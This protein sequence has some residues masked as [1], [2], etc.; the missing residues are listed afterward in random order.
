MIIKIE[1]EEIKRDEPIP[2]CAFLS[3]RYG[4]KPLPIINKKTVGMKP[5]EF[6]ANMTFY[7]VKYSYF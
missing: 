1:L 2:P 5:N 7:K 3:F 6:D 4:G